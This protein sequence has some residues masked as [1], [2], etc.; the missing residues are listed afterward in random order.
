MGGSLEGKWYLQPELASDTSTGRIPEITFHASDGRF[1]GSTGC[2]R[3]SGTFIR[4]DD[5]LQ[6]DSRIVSTRMAC[7]GYNEKPFIDNLLR[8]NHFVIKGGILMLMYNETVLSKWVR[9][10]EDQPIKKA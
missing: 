2:N 5:T 9:H 10:L 4:K 6:F 3:M 1:T 7:I 8:T